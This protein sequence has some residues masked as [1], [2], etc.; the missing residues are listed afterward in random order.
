MN[1]AQPGTFTYT[2]TAT[3]QD[4]QTVTTQI[5]YTVAS[6]PPTT[7]H[8]PHDAD[9]PDHPNH[10]DHADPSNHDDHPDDHAPAGA[11]ADRRDLGDRRHDRV[12]PGH[13][14]PIPRHQPALRAQP[15]DHHPTRATHPR[16]GHFTPVATT[17]LHGHRGINRDRIAGRW[18]GHL[19]PTGPVQILVQIQHDHR[20]TTAKTISL[21]VRHTSR[22]H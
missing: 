3:S 22:H 15:R 20:W 11:S 14:L 17:T 8:H 2:V 1:T 9:H 12:V 7:T 21:T 13:R 19:F 16:H 6:A 4:G 10:A 18:H 5:A